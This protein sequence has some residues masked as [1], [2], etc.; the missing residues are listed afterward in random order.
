MPACLLIH[1]FTGSPNELLDLGDF[2]ERNGVA[3]SIPTLPGHGTHPAD[4]FNY[5]WQ[6]WAEHVQRAFEAFQRKHEDVFVCG[7]SMGGTLALNLA[8]YNTVAGVISLSAPV[9]FPNWQKAGVWFLKHVVKFRKKQGGE[10]VRDLDAKPKLG[11]YQQYPFSAVAELFRLTDHV[12]DE[13]SKIAQPI[14]IMHSVKDHTI[15]FPNAQTIYDSVSSVEKRKF[16][17]RESYHLI[18]VDV[19]KEIVQKEV[20]DF[21]K[22]QSKLI[23][24][25]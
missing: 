5:K 7:L 20:L 22:R 24:S 12:R 6:D 14:L 17:L 21:I 1:G 9:T 16:D 2:L 18:T 15:P 3:V 23:D 13:L 19:E 10:D 25:A 4:M 8:S 11:S